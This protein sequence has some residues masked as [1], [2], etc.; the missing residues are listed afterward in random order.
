MYA[1]CATLPAPGDN[2]ANK[3]A[4]T[5]WLME[6]VTAGTESAFLRSLTW[7]KRRKPAWA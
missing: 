5:L 6:G 1:A 3:P 4:V 2:L 7:S